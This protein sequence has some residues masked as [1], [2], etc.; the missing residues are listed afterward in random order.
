[1]AKKIAAFGFFAVALILTGLLAV[2]Q[3]NYWGGLPSAVEFHRQYDYSSRI[4]P[5]T[6][7]QVRAETGF[8]MT[9]CTEQDGYAS[10]QSG[11]GGPVSA[12]YTDPYYQ[13]VYRLP[14]KSG[15]FWTVD[16]YAVIPDSLASDLYLAEDCIGAQI[17]VNGTNYTISGVYVSD[18]GFLNASFTEPQ[19]FLPFAAGMGA[20][21]VSFA[22]SEPASYFQS[23]LSSNVASQLRNYLAIQPQ[24]EGNLLL[25]LDQVCLALVLFFFLFAAVKYLIPKWKS[26]F[27]HA[28]SSLNRK[29]LSASLWENRTEILRFVLPLLLFLA[30]TT[31]LLL[32]IAAPAPLPS[33][34][35]FPNIFDIG[36]WIHIATERISRI[37]QSPVPSLMRFEHQTIWS[38][39]V[40]IGCVIGILMFLSLAYLQWHNRDKKANS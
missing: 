16:G 22:G 39:A 36:G 8:S 5:E 18:N 30:V 6:L 10:T 7:K 38:I 9:G 4:A 1:M 17:T 15:S 24:R 21:M 40:T 35:T 19:V 34:F 27:Q 12:V 11:R 13:G 37:T 14:M 33:D 25:R 26:L 29:Y 31:V 3:M 28:Q 2:F 23:A 20:D 32:L